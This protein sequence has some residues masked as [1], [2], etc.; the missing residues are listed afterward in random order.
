MLEMRPVYT[1]YE[2]EE[3]LKPFGIVPEDGKTVICARYPDKF[4]GAAYVSADGEV[5]TVHLLSLIDGYSD[6]T[7]IFLLGK[8]MLNYLD[9]HGVKTVVYPEVADTP[10]AR[11]LGFRQNGD[12]WTLSLEGYF[13]GGHSTCSPESH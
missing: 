3:Y 4:V 12:V 8:A 2:R 6:D 11:R 10:L 1:A 5:G 9:L 13:T 7:D